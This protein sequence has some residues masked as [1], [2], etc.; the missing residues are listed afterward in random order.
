MKSSYKDRGDISSR[1]RSDLD[2]QSNEDISE[3]R[4]LLLGPLQAQHEKLR[5][6]L[7]TPALR[8]QDVGDVLPEAIA[9]RA[10]Q[11]KKMEL[12]LEPITARAIRK[13]IQKDRQAM[14]D[15]LFPVMGPAIRKSITTAIQGMVQSFNLLLEHSVSIQGFK[16]RFE[17][18][19][20]HKPFA[21]VVLLHTL[22]YQVEQIFLIH[23]DSG[24]LLQHAVAKTVVV[25]DPDLVSSMLTAIRDFMQDSFGA[26]KEETLDTLSM[27]ERRIWIEQGNHVILAAVIRGNPPLDFQTVLRD[28]VDEIQFQQSKNLA[29]FNGDTAPLEASH[30]I[31]EGCL[32]TQYKKK[33]R[34]RSFI[35]WILLGLVAV[36]VGIWLF[37]IYRDHRLWTQYLTR[38][39]SEPGIVV[40]NIERRSGRHQ[41]RGLR[42]PLASDPQQILQS[43]D[44]D[45]QKV[46]FQWEPYQSWF[47]PFARQRIERILQPPATI[48]LEFK[49]GVLQA[50]G[51]ALRD[52]LVAVRK[53][54]IAIPWI[55]RYEDGGVSD[56]DDIIQPPPSVSLKIVGDQ[57][58]ATGSAS[59]QW[60][61]RTRQLIQSIPGIGGW[62]EDRLIDTDLAAL[63]N[64]RQE[65]QQQIIFMLSSTEAIAPGQLPALLN[66]MRKIKTLD[67][68]ALR[69]GKKVHIEIVGHA[70]SQGPE[71]INL[72]ISRR[73]AERLLAALGLSELSAT[74][75]ST[76]AVGSKE[77]VRKETTPS[78]R[79][80]NRSVTFKVTIHD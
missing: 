53:L 22:V 75:I 39:R 46:V 29:N 60:I 45:P 12:S 26:A 55:V 40:T 38:L 14:V 50:R 21:E 79:E 19:R 36:A 42:D 31:L 73:R 64:I 27:G 1:S 10:A 43:M 17:A 74:R 56:I 13:S 61:V 6:R 30:P 71:D 51:S 32:Q 7:D 68:I 34:K 62:Q 18:L 67:S 66:L 70:D 48:Q 54:V 15:V 58:Q 4:K 63:S 77:P 28:A 80:Y 3:L 11:D 65:L 2:V 47:P 5:K 57:L 41:I 20:T 59:H 23:R 8:A 16:W 69:L 44:L 52:W 78:D 49:E 33:K 25:Q 37:H 9:L 72:A 24:L 76:V 35:P